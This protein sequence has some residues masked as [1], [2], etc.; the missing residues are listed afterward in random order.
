M[1][2]WVLFCGI[3]VLIEKVAYSVFYVSAR[4]LGFRSSVDVLFCPIDEYSVFYS[5]HVIQ[6]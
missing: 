6:G 4:L 5:R 1:L 3:I 2:V